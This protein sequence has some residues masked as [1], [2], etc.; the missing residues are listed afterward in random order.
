MH[1]HG[2]DGYGI[3]SI[4][5]FFGSIDRSEM[6]PFSHPFNPH[7][8]PHPPPPNH[9]PHQPQKK[10]TPTMRWTWRG[11]RCPSWRRWRPWCWWPCGTGRKGSRCVV[12]I[13]GGALFGV[14]LRACGGFWEI[15]TH[16]FR[17]K[18]VRWVDGRRCPRGAESL[19]LQLT[20]TH[21]TSYHPS[22]S[23]G[24]HLSNPHHTNPLHIIHHRTASGG[25]CSPRHAPRYSPC[26]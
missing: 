16:V 26:S 20:P 19:S 8:S 21:S 18:G 13:G 6:H 3:G 2:D 4:A 24:S 11:R 22:P 9:Q 12:V 14:C 17:G 25:Q 23:H 10:A 15:H 5:A 1:S 7:L